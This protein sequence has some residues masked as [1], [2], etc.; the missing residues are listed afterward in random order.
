MDMADDNDGKWL[1]VSSLVQHG[2]KVAEILRLQ[3]KEV[4]WNNNTLKVAYREN[5]LKIVPF[6]AEYGDRLKRYLKSRT[7]SSPNLFVKETGKVYLRAEIR[8]LLATMCRRLGLVYP[9]DSYFRISSSWLYFLPQR[10]SLTETANILGFHL[11]SKLLYYLKTAGLMLPKSVMEI[12]SLEPV[13]CSEDKAAK[14]LELKRLILGV[15]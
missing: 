9:V 7:D 12:P 8:N 4:D 5:Q 10:R 2:I 1:I 13:E 14:V 15:K 6:N 3:I 11:V